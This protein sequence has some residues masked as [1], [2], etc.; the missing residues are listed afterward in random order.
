MI[1][2]RAAVF[3]IRAPGKETMVGPVNVLQTILDACDRAV[4]RTRAESRA[5]EVSKLMEGISF[6]RAIVELPVVSLALMQNLSS[7]EQTL[8]RARVDDLRSSE[9]S[10]EG[11]CLSLGLVLLR[12]LGV[13]ALRAAITTVQ[14]RI[15]LNESLA[16]IIDFMYPATI[17]AEVIGEGVDIPLTLAGQNFDSTA[18]VLLN[19]QVLTTVFD[20]LTNQLHVTLPVATLQERAE[21]EVTVFTRAND[22]GESAPKLLRMGDLNPTPQLDTIDPSS[23]STETVALGGEIELTV[24]GLHFVPDAKVRIDGQDQPTDFANDQK[25]I[26]HVASAALTTPGDHWVTVFNPA[27]LGGESAPGRLTVATPGELHV[28]A[29][30]DP[31]PVPDPTPPGQ[32]SETDNGNVANAAEAVIAVGA[33]EAKVEGIATEWRTPNRYSGAAAPDPRLR[34][35]RSD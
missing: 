9:L 10:N 6:D 3:T 8:L 1:V 21:H 26:A 33:A 27:P 31:T 7:E 4:D 20:P 35:A 14:A 28:D 24:N 19:G 13:D 29:P 23:I 15:K 17:S 11:K 16:P 5:T 25:V 30:P 18:K 2:I 12:S 32:G 34:H 22:G